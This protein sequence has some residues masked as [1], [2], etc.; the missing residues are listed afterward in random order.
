MKK[1]TGLVLVAAISLS[2]G[3][4]VLADT[5]QN[6]INGLL[7]QVSQ[8]DDA[9]GALEFRFGSVNGK[10]TEIS[11]KRSG[12]DFYYITIEGDDGNIANLVISKS[13]YIV[14]NVEITKGTVITGYYNL[15]APMIMIYPP[16]YTT[17]VV[18]VENTEQITKVD[19]FNKELVS[20]DGFLKLNISE[21][22]EIISQKG[23]KYNGT[24]FDKKL[25]VT[26]KNSTR[27]IPAQT[28]PTK[29]VVLDNQV[30]DVS[31]FDIIVNDQKIN[32]LP[33][34]TNDNG[35]V[36]VPVSKIVQALGYSIKW[37]GKTKSATIGKGI[38]CTIGDPNY[39]YYKM[40]PIRLETAPELINGTT[41]VPINFFSDVLHI[42]ADIF[43]GQIVIEDE[44]V[45][46]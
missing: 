5:E 2:V 23:K 39:I 7:S 6:N 45:T 36:M 9:N 4:S 44:N 33:A 24:I 28:T 25:V 3:T 20:S 40:A 34:Y 29:I 19:I 35:I 37:D 41:Y 27:S 18:V 22:T 21:D 13:T 12:S 16:Q 11:E 38:V 10:V 15:N 8:Y 26:Y 31:T 42:N 30:G 14:D 43:G 46:K 1:I 17:E 32:C